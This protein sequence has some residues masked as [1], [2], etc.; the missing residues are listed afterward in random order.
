[1]T[2]VLSTF[3]HQL[4]KLKLDQF[5]CGSGDWRELV[6]PGYLNKGDVNHE[7]LLALE[8]LAHSEVFHV[9]CDWS[10][11]IP[12][13]RQLAIHKPHVIT[14]N[15]IFRHFK[16]LRLIDR[17]VTEVDEGLLKFSQLLEL[18]L[19]GNKLTKIHG[20]H[21]P[22]S[23][24][25]LQ[26]FANNLTDLAELSKEPPALNHLG[27][28]YNQLTDITSYISPDI[29]PTLLSLDLS[30]NKLGDV[31]RT[32]DC[33]AELP[34]LRNL[35]LT[36]NPLTLAPGYYGYS[37]DVMPHLKILDDVSISD[38]E[39]LKYSE[40]KN[41]PL[42]WNEALFSVTFPAIDHLRAPPENEPLDEGGFHYPNQKKYSYYLSFTFITNTELLAVH[43]E[44]ED[45]Q[46]NAD[47]SYPSLA[48]SLNIESMASVEQTHLTEF[49]STE[50]EWADQLMF[51]DPIIIRCPHL[52]ALEEFLNGSVSLRVME[53]ATESFVAIAPPDP[54]TP[55][56]PPSSKGKKSVKVEKGSGKKAKGNTDPVLK[57]KDGN[58]LKWV[59]GA[60]VC[61]EIGY[62]SVNLEELIKGQSIE[63]EG[64]CIMTE[65]PPP[66]PPDDGGRSSSCSAKGKKGKTPAAGK[67]KGKEKVATPVPTEPPKPLSLKFEINRVVWDDI[68]QCR[69]WTS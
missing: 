59:E 49:N 34:M 42:D 65:K 53:R 39:R 61:S 48:D 9:G 38:D 22:R 31:R 41:E 45:M 37:L 32:L 29:W 40:L 19:T 35:S 47:I 30:N 63:G 25:V 21:L 28:G 60:P 27:V 6:D 24:R 54:L 2:T 67:G 56:P 23:M 3:Y 50:V 69:E 33:L 55:S 14:E 15:Y 17:N 16:T 36:G 64:E 46:T 11:E 4:N 7:S 20:A 8:E 5:P 51:N 43:K 66:T 18:S 13:L 68:E 52:V 10:D 62:Y 58:I 44:S 1:M 12:S 26:L 57:D